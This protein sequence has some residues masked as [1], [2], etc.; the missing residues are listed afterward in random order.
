MNVLKHTEST[1]IISENYKPNGNEIQWL[2]SLVLFFT[3]IIY[4]VSGITSHHNDAL[5]NDGFEYRWYVSITLLLCL[6]L[7]NFVSWGKKNTD[8]IFRIVSILF[9]AHVVWMNYNNEFKFQYVLALF[10]AIWGIGILVENIRYIAGFY[11]GLLFSVTALIL[12]VEH[13]ATD[14]MELLQNFIIALLISYIAIYYK[15]KNFNQTKAYFEQIKDLSQKIDRKNKDLEKAYTDIQSGIRY[16]STIQDHILPQNEVLKNRLGYAFVIYRPLDI[17]SGDFYWVERK[18]NRCW[19]AVADCTGHGVPGA[20]ISILGHN[21]LSKAINEHPDAMPGEL[22]HRVNSN[23]FETFSASDK[24][25]RYEGMDIALCMLDFEKEKLIFAGSRRPLLVIGKEGVIQEF[26]GNR[27]IIGMDES[28]PHTFH[29]HE[30]HYE[31]GDMLYVFS[32]GITDQFG[33]QNGKKLNTKRWKELLSKVA[34]KNIVEQEK[35]LNQF[36]DYWM[37]E[38]PQIDDVCILGVQL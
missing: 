10:S 17:V 21:S 26:K 16:A 20:F 34:E 31:K 6:L 14:R 18:N 25:N 12:K 36:L 13:I 37:G 35:E 30:F 2:Y 5:L 3:S 27:E 9:S 11:L 38:L 15:I 28:H 33:G 23:I 4:S 7:I 8:L 32:D 19:F 29:N 1:E 24:N 22:L